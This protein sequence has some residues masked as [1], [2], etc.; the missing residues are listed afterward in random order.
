M[1]H[2]PESLMLCKEVDLDELDQVAKVLRLNDMVRDQTKFM[3]NAL[4]L[5]NPQ[6]RD[7]FDA[8]SLA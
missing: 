6:Y 8:K 2:C 7:S 5:S 3:P 1:L 4:V